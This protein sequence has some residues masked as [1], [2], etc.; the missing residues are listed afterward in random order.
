MERPAAPS[1]A[2][3]CPEPV[4]QGSRGHSLAEDAAASRNRIVDQC[5][6]VQLQQATIARFMAEVLPEKERLVVG[7]ASEA[8]EV[9]IR[10]LNLVR[11]SCEREEQRLLEAAHAEEDRVQQSLL[12]Q[13]AHWKNALRKLDALRTYLVAAIT[14]AD[15]RSLVQAQE[16][17]A[18]R[19]EEA[20][21]ILM[22][23]E[24]KKLNFDPLCTQSPLVSCLWASAVLS[25]ASDEIHMDERTVSPLLALSEDRRTLTFRPKKAKGK[26]DD[27]ARF[28]H[29]PNALAEEAF[30]MGTHVW[31][32]SVAKSCAY[33]LG[34]AYGCLRRKGGGPEARLGYNPFSWVFSRYGKEFQFLHNGCHQKVELLKCPEKIGVVVDLD[35]G[36]LLFLDPQSCTILH[37]HQEAFAGPVYAAL[38][39]ADQ[40]ISLM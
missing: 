17:I 19:I 8:R 4:C 27:A 34:I 39:V 20:E 18:K 2:T 16:E 22:P 35:A 11:S 36:E 21:G 10:R 1:L 14:S 29:W 5:E 15:D 32:V 24:S 33:K 3:A 23:Q 13:R 9:L 28:D 26:P 25:G 37:A 38:A 30:H 31:Q 40:S 6:K 12:T 7:A